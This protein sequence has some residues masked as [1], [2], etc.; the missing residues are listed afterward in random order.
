MTNIDD[1]HE[2]EYFGLENQ[3]LQQQQHQQKERPIREFIF[4]FLEGAISS[5]R[6]AVMPG[7]FEWWLPEKNRSYQD[8]VD[9][10][11]GHPRASEQ[12]G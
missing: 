5:A 7:L 12:T 2:F 11:L 4:F 1:S 9:H 8:A 6:H 10:S 3:L